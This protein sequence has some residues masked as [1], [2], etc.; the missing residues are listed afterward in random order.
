MGLG[1]RSSHSLEEAA[2]TLARYYLNIKYLLLFFIL[3]NYFLKTPNK[4]IGS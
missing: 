4:L 2:N 1:K 3:H